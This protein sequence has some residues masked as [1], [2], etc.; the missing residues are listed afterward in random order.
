[1]VKSSPGVAPKPHSGINLDSTGYSFL[2]ASWRS[3]TPVANAAAVILL[4]QSASPNNGEIEARTSNCLLSVLA[5]GFTRSR[6][7]KLKVAHLG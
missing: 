4:L 7:R 2:L 5:S 1:M 3:T 6:E